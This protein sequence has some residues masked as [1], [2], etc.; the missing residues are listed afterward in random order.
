MPNFALSYTRDGG[1]FGIGEAEPY[2]Q[3]WLNRQERLVLA[4]FGD[5]GGLRVDAAIETLLAMNHVWDTPS[6]RARIGRQ[7]ITRE[8]PYFAATGGDDWLHRLPFPRL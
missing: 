3:Q 1:G 7:P 2:P 5:R 8:P 6:A 4:L